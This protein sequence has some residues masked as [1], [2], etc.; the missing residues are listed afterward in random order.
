[1]FQLLVRIYFSHCIMLGHQDQLLCPLLIGILDNFISVSKQS[2]SM[3]TTTMYA[4]YP[5]K[6][7]QAMLENIRGY[8]TYIDW[9]GD[10]PL[11]WVPFLGCFRIFG[12]L[13]Q[14]FPDFWVSFFLVQFDFFRNNP[15]FWVLILILYFEWHCGILPALVSYFLQSD[16]KHSCKREWQ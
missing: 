11:F 13:F 3:Q 5:L 7:I 16:L 14:L 6:V 8:L 10:V 9:Y 12:Y 15:H 2:L 4:R 1:M